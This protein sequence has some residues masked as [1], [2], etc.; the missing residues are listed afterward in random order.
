M[1][2]R[3]IDALG[4]AFETLRPR[5]GLL[6]RLAGAYAPTRAGATDYC[7]RA[8]VVRSQI[9]GLLAEHLTAAESYQEARWSAA[10]GH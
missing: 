2:G 8:D 6:A 4:A 10:T 7:A 1:V 5:S 3:N 9:H